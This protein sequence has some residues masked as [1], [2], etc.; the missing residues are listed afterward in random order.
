MTFKVVQMIF[1]H[2]NPDI[3]N[4][5]EAVGKVGLEAETYLPTLRSA[6]GIITQE[7]TYI[8]YQ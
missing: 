2:Y 5:D 7:H 4:I 1:L 6:R 8:L 3:V